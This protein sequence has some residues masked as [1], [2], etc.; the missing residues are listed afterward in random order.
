MKMRILKAM[1]SIVVAFSMLAI[2]MPMTIIM[3]T[4]PEVEPLYWNFTGDSDFAD[5]GTAQL[6]LGS[7]TAMNDAG[8][9]QKAAHTNDGIFDTVGHRIDAS[10]PYGTLAIQ[11]PIDPA[12]DGSKY[13]RIKLD[14]GA[15]A[16]AAFVA[17]ISFGGATVENPDYTK[18]FTVEHLNSTGLVELDMSTM[19]TWTTNTSIDY[20]R[21]TVV[22]PDN[23]WNGANRLLVDY[24][25]ICPKEIAPPPEPIGDIVY[26]F[27]DGDHD[28]KKAWDFDPPTYNLVYNDTE[29]AMEGQML[30]GFGSISLQKHYDPPLDITVYKTLKV[31][32]KNPT[33][34]PIMVSVGV[35]TE[36]DQSTIEGNEYPTRFEVAGNSNEYVDYYVQ[37]AEAVNSLWPTMNNL[38]Y[39][40]VQLCVGTGNMT[41]G[42]SIFVKK[43]ELLTTKTSAPPAEVDPTDVT[44]DFLSDIQGFTGVWGNDTQAS[45]AHDESEMGL[46]VTMMVDGEGAAQFQRGLDAPIDG[47]DY[48]TVKITLKNTTGKALTGAFSYNLD[49]DGTYVDNPESLNQFNI[50]ADDGYVTYYIQV[51]ENEHWNAAEAINLVRFYVGYNDM[52]KDGVVYVSRIEILTDKEEAS[53]SGGNETT[54]TSKTSDVDTDKDGGVNTGVDTYVWFAGAIMLFAA[55]TA[56]MSVKKRQCIGK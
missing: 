30:Q 18:T 42:E 22:L 1:L 40:R 34:K 4:G 47:A 17:K 31:S 6:K 2:A 38:A 46:K 41:P 25:E 48:K 54:S 27:T 55:L 50:T 23:S 26:D 36:E 13:D 33:A 35:C 21:I 49:A 12:I 43:I 14:I 9:W 29:K 44:F 45:I 15:F 52:V 5:G 32:I 20:L 51:G 37:V 16:S 53:N 28:F 11:T 39:L 3:A 56:V 10:A 24:V 8:S 7:G 19:E